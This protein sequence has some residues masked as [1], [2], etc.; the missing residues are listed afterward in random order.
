M[1]SPQDMQFIQ[2]DVTNACNLQCSNCTRFCGNHKKPFVMDM[3]TF[4]RA[5]DSLADYDGVTGIIGGEPTVHPQFE[6]MARYI[7]SVHGR[8]KDIMKYPEKDFIHKMQQRE[9][10]AEQMMER[11]DGT[12][13]LKKRGAGLWSNMSATYRKHYEIIQDTFSVQFLNDH[14]NASYHQPGLFSRKDLGIPDEEWIPLRDNCWMQNSWSATITPKG[15][16]FCEV[17]GALDML[18][19]GPGGWKIE[20]NWWK[21]QP[22]DFKD[23]LQ[24]CEICGFALKN[25]FSRDAKEEIDDVSPSVYEKLKYLDSP[26]FKD[27][28]INLVKIENGK[29]AEE[30]KAERPPFIFGVCYIE[31]YEDR[32][33]KENSVLFDMDYEECIV[34]DIDELGAFLTQRLRTES[35]E[36]IK[37]GKTRWMLLKNSR[38]V[39]TRIL[40]DLI[41]KTVFNSGVL[42]K[43]EGYLF[44]SKLALCLRDIGFDG[45]KEIRALDDI[46]KAWVP[47]KVVSIA[48]TERMTKL[49]SDIIEIGKSYAVWGAGI[50][51]EYFAK[52]IRLSGGSVPFFVDK[53]EEKQ[54][55]KFGGI[56]ICSPDEMMKRQ[57]EYDV[58][59]IANH[60]HFDEIKKEALEMGMAEK[61]IVMPFEMIKSIGNRG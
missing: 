40:K 38:S 19:N 4:R 23:Q 7:Q 32:F 15:A 60:T 17:A 57:G 16:F 22:E 52:T 26:K 30:S 58:L 59:I 3:E 20:K 37:T 48:D 8:Q 35:G 31:N 14:L 11:A 10:S 33:Q 44:F 50:L 5:V 54:G 18:F 56:Q 49:R 9:F 21:R 46:V 53:S 45:L 2:I 51:G 13:Y 27:G 47:E 39:D 29:I 6:D 55:Q 12:H 28:R 61:K 1:K 43:G 36:Q 34:E 24:W 41:G 25:I 42:H